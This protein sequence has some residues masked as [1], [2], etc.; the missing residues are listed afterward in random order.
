MAQ[1]REASLFTSLIPEEHHVTGLIPTRQRR[2]SAVRRPGKPNICPDLNLVKG[3]GV[4]PAKC[5]CR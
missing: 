1:D 3:C 2:A 5:R 4:R